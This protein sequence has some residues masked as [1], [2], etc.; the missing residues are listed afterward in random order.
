MLKTKVIITVLG[1]LAFESCQA[2]YRPMPSFLDKMINQV[3]ENQLET[4]FGK[5]IAATTKDQLEQRFGKLTKVGP[6]SEAIQTAPQTTISTTTMVETTTRSAGIK[7]TVRPETHKLKLCHFKT[8]EACTLEEWTKFIS[9]VLE[10]KKD[11]K[12]KKHRKYHK[13][14][15][16]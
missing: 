10:D 9:H 3:L 15:M 16:F 5:L 4:R 12:N 11:S 13:H 8:F 6:Q 2:F 1:F 14:N 7:T